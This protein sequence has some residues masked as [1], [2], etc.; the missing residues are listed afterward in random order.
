MHGE[1]SC[2]ILFF[3]F[4]LFRN[5]YIIALNAVN[6]DDHYQPPFIIVCSLRYFSLV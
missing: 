1:I 2:S 6:E 3:C 5:L 4:I